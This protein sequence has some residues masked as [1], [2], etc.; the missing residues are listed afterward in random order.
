ML[1]GF[2]IYSHCKKNDGKWLKSCYK[3]KDVILGPQ[4]FVIDIKSDKKI[5]IPGFDDFNP[6]LVLAQK[7]TKVSIGL[8]EYHS[9]T[10]KRN[11][12]G[13]NMRIVKESDCTNCDSG[14]WGNGADKTGYQTPQSNLG[15]FSYPSSE[16][17]ITFEEPGVYYYISI[18]YPDII[19]KII[20]EASEDIGDDTSDYIYSEFT[21]NVYD[22]CDLDEANGYDFTGK[23]IKDP[24]GRE[25]SGYGYVAS[26]DYPYVMPKRKRNIMGELW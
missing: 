6:T 2:P 9:Y 1:D 18:D 11:S 24:Y 8:N 7:G 15:D 19:G 12:G 23:G 16:L 3:L 26:H 10:F 25:I 4:E 20:V 13:Y 5:S 17:E 14:S 21:T 22:D